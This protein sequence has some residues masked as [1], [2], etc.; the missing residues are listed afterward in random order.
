[1]IN[2]KERILAIK[3]QAILDSWDQSSESDNIIYVIGTKQKNIYGKTFTG[4]RIQIAKPETNTCIKLIE[5]A[6]ITIWGKRKPK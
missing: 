5:D 3:V 1:M 4:P 2:L 6:K